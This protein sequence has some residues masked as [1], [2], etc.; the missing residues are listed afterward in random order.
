MSPAK[1]LQ[2]VLLLA[3]LLAAAAAAAA[4]CRSVNEIKTPEIRLRNIHVQGLSGGVA[5]VVLEVMVDNA[6]D[7]EVRLIDLTA[8][9][10]LAGAQ[11]GEVSWS[12]EFDCPRERASVLR[13]PLRLTVGE[14]KEVFSTLIDRRQP[15]RHEL[16]GES[17][18]AHG[19]IRHTYPLATEGEIGT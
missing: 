3:L 13:I 6:N 12:G 8:A 11:V 2:A 4:G 7:F 17:T 5:D 14:H 19:V 10:V 9:I 1:P 18:F 15:L 16:R